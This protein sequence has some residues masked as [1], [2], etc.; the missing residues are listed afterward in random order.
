MASKFAIIGY[1]GRLLKVDKENLDSIIDLLL[2]IEKGYR[3]GERVDDLCDDVE[4][5]I[6]H[7][8]KI[9]RK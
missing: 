4:Q 6:S 7:F 2:L 8:L 5:K 1:F 9:Y 3:K